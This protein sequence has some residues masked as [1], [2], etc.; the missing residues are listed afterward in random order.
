MS[1][2]EPLHADCERGCSRKHEAALDSLTQYRHL[3][4]ALSKYVA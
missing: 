2:L 4:V 3:T 1:P